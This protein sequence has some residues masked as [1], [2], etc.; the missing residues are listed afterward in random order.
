MNEIELWAARNA[1]SGMNVRD[2]PHTSRTDG[3]STTS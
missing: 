2:T 1:Q 3:Y